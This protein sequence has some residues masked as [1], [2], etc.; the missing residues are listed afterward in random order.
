MTKLKMST[1]MAT[2]LMSGIAG[3]AVVLVVGA[4]VLKMTGIGK[5]QRPSLAVVDVAQLIKAQATKVSLKTQDPKTIDQLAEGFMEKLSLAMD[6]VA[7]DKKVILL[8]PQAVAQT[9]VENLTDEVALTLEFLE[10]E[11]LP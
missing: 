9:Q 8:Q 2:C 6:M 3:G 11:S 4:I 7:E 5:P 1:G 10:Q